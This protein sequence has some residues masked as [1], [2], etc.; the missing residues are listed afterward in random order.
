MFLNSAE[1]IAGLAIK[2]GD[3]E[4]DW[5]RELAVNQLHTHLSI[6]ISFTNSVLRLLKVDAGN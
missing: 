2:T 4:I 5:P 1:Q 3:S 6:S